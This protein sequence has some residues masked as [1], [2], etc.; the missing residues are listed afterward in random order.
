[1]AFLLFPPMFIAGN[2]YTFRITWPNNSSYC[3]FHQRKLSV[4]LLLLFFFNNN[5][6]GAY[7][8]LPTPP[9]NWSGYDVTEAE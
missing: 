1:M 2:Y 4:L 7:H 6:P 9:S 8:P 3:Y 5:I